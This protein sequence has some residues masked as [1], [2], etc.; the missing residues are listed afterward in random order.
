MSIYTYIIIS[1]Y[2]DILIL[3]N[4][5]LLLAESSLCHCYFHLSPITSKI[6]YSKVNFSKVKTKLNIAFIKSVVLKKAGW[7]FKHKQF[8]YIK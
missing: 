6:K 5:Y 4:C 3:S 2:Y 7:V 8:L 1:K